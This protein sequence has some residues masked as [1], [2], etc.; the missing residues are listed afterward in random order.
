[1]QGTSVDKLLAL[2]FMSVKVKP[3]KIG[4]ARASLYVQITEI[5][6]S[7]GQF[8]V[9]E[10]SKTCLKSLDQLFQYSYSMKI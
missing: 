3:S 8:Y 1:M 6:L 10:N 7:F 9:E 5:G 2:S 4:H